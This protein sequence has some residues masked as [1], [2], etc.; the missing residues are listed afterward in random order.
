MRLLELEDSRWVDFVHGRPD[1][2]LFHHPE[3]AGLLAECYGFRAMGVVLA[4]RGGAVQA[5]LPVIE[6]T[7]PLGGRRWVSLPFTDACPPLVGDGG[8]LIAELMEIAKSRKLAAVE[9]RDALPLHPAVQSNA[10]FVRHTLTF[11]P[12]SPLGPQSLSTN[13]RRN[14]RAAEREGIRIARGAAGS[15]LETFYRLHVQTRRRLGVPIQPRRFFGL[16]LERVLRRGLGFVL[17]A[18]SGDVPVASA[19]FSSW[20]GT[21]IYKYGARDERS[22][23]LGA[24]HLLMWTAL[25][26]AEENG[27]HT[28]DLGRSNLDQDQLRRFKSGWAAR[29]E[30]LAYSWIARAPIRPSSHRLEEAMAL[31]I[32]N[33]GSWVCQTLGELF[34]RYAA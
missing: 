11:S 34:Y 32:R 17:S 31:V 18:Y 20:N 1:A 8:T 5:G 30:P 9:V 10:P 22:A 28:V 19:V 6:V 33:S 27:C 29:E 7:R 21:L 25:R 24:N 26:W 15:D 4:E 2:T 23:K 13:H 3:W 14:L 12:D 16:L